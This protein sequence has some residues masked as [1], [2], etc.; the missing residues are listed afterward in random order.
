MATHELF[1]QVISRQLY[2]PWASVGSVFKNKDK[3]CSMCWIILN[4][5]KKHTIFS[6][7]MLFSSLIV[8]IIIKIIQSIGLCRS[9]FDW[10]CFNQTSNNCFDRIKVRE[11]QPNT[12]RWF[13][14]MLDRV[15]GNSSGHFK[16]DR[17]FS[18]ISRNLLTSSVLNFR[19]N[20]VK[21]G[22]SWWRMIKNEFYMK[23]MY[24]SIE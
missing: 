18:M 9:V 3:L 21:H 13:L 2:Q 11:M 7:V 17:K 15:V 1:L 22:R 19:I 24:W 8:I 5:G 10:M 6:M 4:I 14:W 23:K 16:H 20:F 12:S